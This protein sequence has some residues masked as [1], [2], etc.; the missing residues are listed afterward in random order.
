MGDLTEHVVKVEVR[1]RTSNPNTDAVVENVMRQVE[2]AFGDAATKGYVE[3]TPLQVVRLGGAW[4]ESPP[5]PD[6]KI[7][8]CQHCEERIRQNM[9]MVWYH[10]GGNVFCPGKSV[11]PHGDLRM[12]AEPPTIELDPPMSDIDTL[13]AIKAVFQAFGEA[14]AKVVN[15]D[16]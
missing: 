12:R 4:A 10:D 9:N 7:A 3:V 8:V 5:P 11:S 13:K 16:G 2:L 6:D 1:I 14:Y 15:P